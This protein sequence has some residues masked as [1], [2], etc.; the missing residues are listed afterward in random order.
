MKCKPAIKKRVH[1]KENE[2]NL[3]NLE[4]K[5]R[6]KFFFNSPDS[7][8]PVRDILNTQGRGEKTEPHIEKNA[9]NYSSGCYQLNVI[10]PFLRSE[11]KYL[12]LFTTC[13]NKELKGY[14]NR[15]F[16]VG[17]ITKENVLW[18][19]DHWAV[20]GKTY[21]YSFADAYPLTTKSNPRH[22]QRLKSEKETARILDHF[23]SR[24]NILANCIKEISRLKSGKKSKKYPYSC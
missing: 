19:S 4:E 8:Y 21:V 24:T 23:E 2:F 3:Y 20:Q 17:Y 12:F 13:K 1:Q 22:Q 15:Q 10:I 16:I 5:G 9:E 14:Y 11:E 18:R 6:I 7:V